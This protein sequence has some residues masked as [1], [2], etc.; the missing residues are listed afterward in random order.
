MQ[1]PDSELCETAGCVEARR[2]KMCATCD[3][4]LQRVCPISVSRRNEG[5]EIISRL[6]IIPTE[7]TEQNAQHLFVFFFFLGVWI[8][9]V[10]SMLSA[11]GRK[12]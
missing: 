8:T 12:Y 4:A 6:A 7:G 10:A 5:K 3:K 11:S 2:S 9:D 1:W